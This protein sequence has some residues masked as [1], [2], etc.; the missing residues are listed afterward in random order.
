MA[1]VFVAECK[2]AVVDLYGS[3]PKSN[4]DYSRIVSPST[5]KRL[6]SLIDPGKVVSG[7]KFDE[8]AR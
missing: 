4:P 8:S 1:D 7:G 5:V 2:K 3:D 6:I